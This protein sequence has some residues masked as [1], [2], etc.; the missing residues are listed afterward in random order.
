MYAIITRVYNSG[1]TTVSNPVETKETRDS[2]TTTNSYD[3]Y[4]DVFKTKREAMQF[5]KEQVD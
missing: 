5:K 4:R 1:R 2:K 3:E